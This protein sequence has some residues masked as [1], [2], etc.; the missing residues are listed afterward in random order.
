MTIS[1][2][3]CIPTLKRWASALILTSSS[4]LIPHFDNETLM[5]GRFK[6]LSCQTTRTPAF[7]LTALS[8]FGTLL[9]T[10][11]MQILHQLNISFTVLCIRLHTGI[12][13]YSSLLDLCDASCD[14]AIHFGYPLWTTFFLPAPEVGLCVQNSSCE[15]LVSKNWSLCVCY[16]QGY[17]QLCIQV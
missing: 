16:Y 4:H 14:G 1:L 8:V 13:P 15:S 9:L 3:L 12:C 10:S 11:W 7:F 2:S 17:I 5:F 6:F